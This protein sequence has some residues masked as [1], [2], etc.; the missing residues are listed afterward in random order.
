VCDN[1]VNY[2]VAL[3]SGEIIN[4]NAKENSDLWLALRGGGNNF[5]VVTRYDMKTF[6]QGPL[7]GGSVYYFAH[8]FPS[9]IEALVNEIQ[10]PDASEETHLMIS[11]GYAAQF[12]QTVCQNQVYYTQAVEKPAVLEPFTAIQPQIEQ[13]NSIRMMSLKEASSEQ[14]NDVRDR[15]R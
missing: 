9:Q 1:V 10:K 7:W 14:A 13:M 11:I 8:S 4:A 15:Q 3:A 2:E 5:G 6:K 12:G